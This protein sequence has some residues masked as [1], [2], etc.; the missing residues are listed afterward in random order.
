MPNTSRHTESLQPL[1]AHPDEDAAVLDAT[2]ADAV[3][4]AGRTER[5]AAAGYPTFRV[6][7]EDS[8]SG[9]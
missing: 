7:D 5:S 1:A 9:A 8:D 4:V 3:A 2:A 6:D